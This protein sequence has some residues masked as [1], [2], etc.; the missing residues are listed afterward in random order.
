MSCLLILH[1]FFWNSYLGR[2]SKQNFSIKI[3]RLCVLKKLYSLRI[4]EG[5]K[6]LKGFPV[7]QRLKCL[8]PMRETGVRSLGPEGPL[9][10][11]MVTHSNILAWRIPW[12]EKPSRLHTVHRV[13]KSRTG[14]SDFTFTL[15][16]LI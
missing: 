3:K 11:E 10:K 7:A 12:M 16:N 9:E 15:K 2:T 4:R 14:L 6:Q 1:Q 8:P 13:A 5:F